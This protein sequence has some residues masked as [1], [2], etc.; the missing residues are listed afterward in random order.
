MG[1]PL[2]SSLLYAHAHTHSSHGRTYVDPRV[3]NLLGHDGQQVLVL[4]QLGGEVL[5][6]GHV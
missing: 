1:L 2:F 6:G 4:H 5:P 3:A